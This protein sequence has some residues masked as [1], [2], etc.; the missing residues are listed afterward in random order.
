MGIEEYLFDDQKAYQ[1]AGCNEHAL[2]IRFL[3]TYSD[4]LGKILGKTCGIEETAF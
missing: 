4:V 1:R 3:L 2:L